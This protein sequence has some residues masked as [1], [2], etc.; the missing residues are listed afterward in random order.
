[1]MKVYQWILFDADET[2]FKF[3]AYR[4]L[5]HMFEQYR[6][7]FSHTDYLRYEAINKPLWSQYQQGLI[8][9][10]TIH[11]LRFAE[12]SSQLK[13]P[14][15]DLNKSF[16]AAMID[17]CEPLDGA[18]NLLNKLQGKIKLGIITNGYAA[19]QEIRL[20][21]MGLQEHFEILIISEEVGFAKPHKAIFEHALQKMGQ[22]CPS[23]VLMVGDTIDSDILG[24]LNAGFDTC[25]LNHH[26]QLPHPHITPHYEISSLDQLQQ[27]L[28][29]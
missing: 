26:K 17:I 6:I 2:L 14:S 9:A 16:I 3:D 11:Q 19:L 20:K 5:R 24:G 22:P 7:N 8:D 18:L 27:I 29:Y 1:M 23:S 28:K 10:K 4:G 12:W 15:A 25:W 21:K 13:I